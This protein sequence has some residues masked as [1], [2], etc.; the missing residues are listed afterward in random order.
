MK[1]LAL[2]LLT[3][4]LQGCVQNI[5]PTVKNFDTLIPGVVQTRNVGEALFEKGAVE[6]VPGFLVQ[7]DSNLPLIEHLL[8]PPVKRGDLWACTE[9]LRNGEY[10][11]TNPELKLKD[12][13]T[14]SGET[15][16]H[17]LPQ[18]IIG[19]GGEFRGVYFPETG[20]ISRQ[21]ENMLAGLF[22]PAEAPL[23]GSFKHELVYN[24]RTDDNIK[25]IYREFTED[26]TKPVLFQGHSFNISSLDIIR[27]K[28][29]IIEVV[30]ANESSI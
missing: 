18:F 1:I 30:E 4:T 29:V 9:K 28:D 7:R 10:L 24:G 6:M 22:A 14:D 2:L 5:S 21:D 3:F 13:Q 15:F 16:Q 17:R 25:L 8:F 20:Y 26:L 23:N 11:C 27:V 19:R 12:V